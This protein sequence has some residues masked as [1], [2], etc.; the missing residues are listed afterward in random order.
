MYTD[1]NRVKRLVDWCVD[2]QLRIERLIYDH[3][4]GPGEWCI[5]H[6]NMWMPQRAVW[7]NGDPVTVTATTLPTDL[8]EIYRGRVNPGLNRWLFRR[9]MYHRSTG[10]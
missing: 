3:A 7:V 1:P 8:A 2:C 5:G 10:R 6:M 4:Q 9:H